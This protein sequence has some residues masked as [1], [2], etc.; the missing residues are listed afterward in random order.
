MHRAKAHVRYYIQSMTDDPY[1]LSRKFPAARNYLV[2]M[3]LFDREQAPVVASDIARRLAVSPAAVT[4]SLSRLE[5]EGFLRRHP[6]RG[7]SL[8]DEGLAISKRMMS[9]HYLLERLLVDRLGVAWDV[10]DQEADHLEQGLSP[11]M[12]AVLKAELGYPKTCPHGNPFPDSD[13]E[14][15][16][17]S[18]PPIT[19]AP[20][21]SE[22]TIVRVTEWG[23]MVP[24]LLTFCAQHKIQIGSRFTIV[25]SASSPRER[26]SVQLTPIG[27]SSS[28]SPKSK[29]VIPYEFASYIC[30]S[31]VAA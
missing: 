20:T 14:A 21:G 27:L 17:L 12:E 2:H 1:E 30:F 29:V 13:S 25:E 6:V 3:F 15:R 4:Q 11:R 23:E 18:A 19:E 9:R 22:V 26:G 16:I 24:G 28:T 31:L 8:T 7:F 5:K 10:A